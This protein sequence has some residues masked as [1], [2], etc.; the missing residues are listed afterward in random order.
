MESG[1]DL[2]W[3]PCNLGGSSSA[4]GRGTR[5]GFLGGVVRG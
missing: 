5:P 2:G 1:S 4:W 3:I